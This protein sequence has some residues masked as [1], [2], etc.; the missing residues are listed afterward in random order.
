MANQIY[1]DGKRDQWS[2]GGVGEGCIGGQ[3]LLEQWN[4]VLM[5]A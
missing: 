2:L 1:S 3:G 5:G 4:P